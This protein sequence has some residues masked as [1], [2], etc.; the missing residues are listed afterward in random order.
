MKVIDLIR[1][2]KDKT[3]FS[4]E[5]LPPKKG[6]SINVLYSCIDSLMEFDPAF[7]DVTYSR[8][9]IKEVKGKNG[10]TIMKATRKR[11][12]TVG[13]CAAIINRYHVD[14]VPHLICGGFTKDETEDALIDLDFLGIDNILAMQGDK[15]DTEKFFAPTKG[16][17]AYA[18]ELIG[19]IVNMNKGEYLDEELGNT[20]A[21]DFCISAACYPE[22]H[23]AAGS[24][25][26]DLK[27]LKQKVDLG[28]E[29]LVTQ[30]FFD[31]QKYFD[32]VDQCRA[33][34]IDVPIIPG[35]KPLSTKKQL[36]ILPDIFFTNIPEA[37]RK[38]VEK[39]EDNKA[40][41]QIGI[42]WATQQSIEL[43]KAGVPV[44]HYYTMS[45]AE[46]TKEIARNVF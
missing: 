11:P 5:V 21:T 17:H 2:R 6:E 32:F 3:L 7:I 37:L 23:Y 8:Q 39:A 26:E 18:S 12:G 9:Q 40:V 38:E 42:E 10:E 45:K 24:M 46:L 43:K 22:K 31:N 34:G 28:A 41:R 13:I 16:G 30:M 4:F 33:I 29:Y 35:I 19:Q 44:L 25:E 15:M 20:A 27:Y 36:E 14:V 1:N